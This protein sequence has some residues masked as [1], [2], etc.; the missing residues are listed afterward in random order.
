MQAG[1]LSAQFGAT[2]FAQRSCMQP[3]QKPTRFVRSGPGDDLHSTQP[4]SS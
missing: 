4:L 2:M 1:A 3:S